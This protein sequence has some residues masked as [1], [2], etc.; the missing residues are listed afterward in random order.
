MLQLDTA[1]KGLPEI[2][3]SYRDYEPTPEVRRQIE[4]LL[5]YVPT[6]YLQ[7]LKTIVLTNRAAL[8]RDQHRQKVWS[9][10][11]KV[12]LAIARGAYYE[13]TRSRP[14]TI[15]LYVDNMLRGHP[16]GTRV[17]PSFGYLPILQVL[18]HEIGHHI[19]AVH[20]RG[21]E[22][23]ENVAEEWSRKLGRRF[24]LRVAY[25][26]DYRQDCE[27]CPE[28]KEDEAYRSAMV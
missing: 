15:W 17:Y 23:K 21:Y 12:Q 18:Y 25:P 1:Q 19:H 10:N 14:A 4:I 3:E 26:L 6:E 9:R 5:Q 13:A 28:G 11:R 22:G 24:Y 7:G 8:A 20:R 16:V 2:V 27:S